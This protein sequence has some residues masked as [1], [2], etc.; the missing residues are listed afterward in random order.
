MIVTRFRDE[1]G[2][3]LHPEENI[4]DKAL[5]AAQFVLCMIS[6]Q[7][8]KDF[9]PLQQD[10]THRNSLTNCLGAH[11]S[12]LSSIGII[13]QREKE[14]GNFDFRIPKRPLDVSGFWRRIK[15]YLPFSYPLMVS[16]RAVNTDHFHYSHMRFI[17]H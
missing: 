17:E 7:P 15:E 14:P 10:Y 16:L 12:H 1:R 9:L 6:S 13:Q 2:I 11:P 3:V 8:M 4:H 5:K